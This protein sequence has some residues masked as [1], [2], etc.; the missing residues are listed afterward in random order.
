NN[1]NE[2]AFEF[3]RYLT[4]KGIDPSKIA[5]LIFERNRPSVI[6]LLHR[7]LSTLEMHGDG[8]NCLTGCEKGFYRRD[9]FAGGRYRRIC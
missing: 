6:H 4:S 2:E 9:R 3:A 1:V 5:S 7:V 8:K